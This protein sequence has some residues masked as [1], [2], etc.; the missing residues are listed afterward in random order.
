M[1]NPFGDSP[2]LSWL[3]D[4]LNTAGM[5]DFLDIVWRPR[6]CS[7]ARPEGPELNN[8]GRQVGVKDADQMRAGAELKRGRIIKCRTFGA[9]TLEILIPALRPGLLTDGP[10][11][12]DGGNQRRGRP[13]TL[14]V[15]CVPQSG[16]SLGGSRSLPFSGVCFT[17]LLGLK[18]TSTCTSTSTSTSTF[19]KTVIVDVA[20]DGLLWRGHTQERSAA[21]FPV[22][23]RHHFLR[24]SQRLASA[25]RLVHSHRPE[26]TWVGRRQP[27]CRASMT[28][29]PR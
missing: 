5:D 2:A 27:S 1:Y 4:T 25:E 21:I 15:K 8:P 19:T 3:E 16:L 29:W 6:I 9:R 17:P 12:L 14:S 26:V 20:V 10:T 23:A 28:I 7:M 11:G 24:H 22:T 18:K 13:K